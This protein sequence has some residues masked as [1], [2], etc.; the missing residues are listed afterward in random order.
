MKSSYQRRPHWLK[1]RPPAG[2]NFHEVRRLVQETQ[3]HTVCQSAHCPNIGECWGRRTATFM[4]LGEVCT[5]NCRFCAVTSG[6]PQPVDAQEPQRIAQA[7]KTLRLKYAVITSVT[8]DDLPDGGAHQ[9]A[10][11]IQEIRQQVPDCRVEVLIPDFLGVKESLIKVLEARPTVLNH[12]LETVPRLYEIVRPE[13][14]YQRSLTLLK[15]AKTS[16]V[17]TK[18]GLMVGLGETMDEIQQVMHDLRAVQCDLLTIGQY[19]EPSRDH[20]PIARFVP[21]EEFQQL[22]AYGLALGFKMVA[23][24]PLVRSS[25]QADLAL[26]LPVEASADINESL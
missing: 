7:V 19:L 1:V 6:P 8:R 9:F 4:I 12:N 3:L 24:A 10:Q 26:K 18:S 2:D 16:G 11:T 15:R 21:P 25:Y 14:D 5:R 17:T 13:A 22:K 20:L 23:A